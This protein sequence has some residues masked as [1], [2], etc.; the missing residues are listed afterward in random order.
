M[1]PAQF[2]SPT[3]G[4]KQPLPALTQWWVGSGEEGLVVSIS[5]AG[6]GRGI[7]ELPH[8]ECRHVIEPQLTPV[9]YLYHLWCMMFL[10]GESPQ[11]PFLKGEV[12]IL[13]GKGLSPLQELQRD[14]GL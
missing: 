11:H 4:K 1:F 7:T 3:S 9:C 8:S 12:G 6:Q 10:K 14:L 13:E 2:P 5:R